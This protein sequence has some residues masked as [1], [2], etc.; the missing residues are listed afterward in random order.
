MVLSRVLIEQSNG[1]LDE[2]ENSYLEIIERNGKHLLSLINDILDLSK[3]EAGKMEVLINQV[4]VGNLLK[5]VY[6]NLQIL[7]EK[8]GLKLNLVL[9]NDIPIIESDETKLHQI[10]LNF[11]GNAIKFTEK[12]SVDI[13]LNS[14]SEDVFIE[15]KDSGIGI[16]EEMLPYIFDE[17]RQVDGTSTREYEGSGLGLAIA[18]KLITLIGGSVSVE[19]ELGIGSSFTITL[20]IKWHGEENE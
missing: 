19:S 3:I 9:Q 13:S 16:S 8:K 2:E 11:V 6:E 1:K 5:I 20:P 7:S 17:F 4:S 15:V 10:L 14:D 18:S 12:G